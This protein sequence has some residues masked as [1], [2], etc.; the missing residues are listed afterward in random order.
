V[1]EHLSAEMLSA[2]A[3]GELAESELTAAQMHIDQCLSCARQVVHEYLL[4]AQITESGRRYDAQPEFRGRMA[5]LAALNVETAG[6][7]THSRKAPEPKRGFTGAAGWIVAAV[8]LLAVGAGTAVQYEVQRRDAARDAVNAQLAEAIDVHIATL[9]SSEQPQVL[10]SDR[11]TVKPWFQGKLPFSFNI[12]E[13]LPAGTTLDGANFVYLNNR[14]VAQLLF[15]IGHHRVSVF[16]EQRSGNNATSAVATSRAGFQVQ[17][18]STPELNAV[19]V[20]DVDRSR[21]QELVEAVKD[22][23]AQ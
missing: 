11:H 12:P 22:A 7:G 18:F 6:D 5:K 23:Q 20:S 3:G 8:I 13:L 9:A 1:S 10:S 21:L 2:F 15:S 16:V 19:A 17:S 4:K 14:P